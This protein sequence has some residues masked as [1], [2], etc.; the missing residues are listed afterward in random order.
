MLREVKINHYSRT[1]LVPPQPQLLQQ[2]EKTG[3]KESRGGL[4][5]L[6]ERVIGEY[7]SGLSRRR[8]STKKE[9][10]KKCK[11]EGRSGEIMGEVLAS[12]RDMLNLWLQLESMDEMEEIDWCSQVRKAAE[13]GD[14]ARVVTVKLAEGAGF[15]QEEVEACLSKSLEVRGKIQFIS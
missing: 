4:V 2:K 9:E 1:V 8:R 6:F 10:M 14:W 11:T 7:L 15:T 12:T 3:L 13:R 5:G